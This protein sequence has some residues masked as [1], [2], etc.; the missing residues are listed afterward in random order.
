TDSLSVSHG[1]PVHTDPCH[2]E[3]SEGSSPVSASPSQRMRKMRH[4]GSSIR[5]PRPSKISFTQTAGGWRFQSEMTQVDMAHDSRLIPT[6]LDPSVTFAKSCRPSWSNPKNLA[7]LNSLN[8][9][10]LPS[11]PLRGL[12]WGD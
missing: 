9:N 12:R 2:P 7:H 6:L 1:A 10:S 8:L 11:G 4:S 5:G 3:R